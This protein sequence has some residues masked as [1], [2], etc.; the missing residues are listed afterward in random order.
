M[1]SNVTMSGSMSAAVVEVGAVADTT[2]TAISLW[3]GMQHLC[4]NKTGTDATS[5]LTMTTEP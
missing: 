3:G 5:V 2:C 1:S 4:R